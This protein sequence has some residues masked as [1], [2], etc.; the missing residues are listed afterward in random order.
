MGGCQLCKSGVPRADIGFANGHIVYWGD[1][2]D[3]GASAFIPCTDEDRE[4][5]AAVGRK[6]NNAQT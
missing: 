6:L 2:D 3:G 5:C 4:K 1:L